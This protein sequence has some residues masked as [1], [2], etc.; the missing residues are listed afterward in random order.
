MSR[1]IL[2]SSIYICI[3]SLLLTNISFAQDKRLNVYIDTAQLLI[4]DHRHLVFEF[5]P[6]GQ[7]TLK[8]PTLQDSI[9]KIELVKKGSTDTIKSEGKIVKF[10]QRHIVTSFDTG[11]HKIPPFNFSV[12]K[13]DSAK[14]ETL[15]S[16]TLYLLTYGMA[17]DTTK[18]IRDIKPPI[19]MPFSFLDFLEENAGYIAIV[20]AIAGM[21]WAFFYWRSKKA[22]PIVKVPEVQIPPDEYAVRQLRELEKEKLWQ[23]GQYKEYHSRVSDIVRYYIERRYDV[24]ALELTT[25]ETIALLRNLTD[26][27][28]N[29]LLQLLQLA[30]LVKFA[31][32][33]PLQHDNDLSLKNAY[34]FI[35]GTRTE[36]ALNRKEE[37]AS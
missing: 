36:N 2:F 31:K 23:T 35:E 21:V 3:I 15:S 12:I 5:T 11:R 8:F 10:V 28:R 13:G 27:Q 16:D 9:G 30:D 19:E 26:V 1:K 34:S 24:R 37:K 7:E 6:S 22:K 25:D 32:A 4:G 14:V 33:T 20:L 18:E 29:Q 17:V